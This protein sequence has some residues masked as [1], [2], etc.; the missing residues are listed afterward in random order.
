MSNMS[1]MSKQELRAH[2]PRPY[3]PLPSTDFDALKA[4]Y[5]ASPLASEEDTFALIRIIGND[6][7]PRHQ[8]GQSRMNLE[9][10]LEHEPKFDACTKVWVLN[11]IV[12]PD[13]LS[14]LKALLEKYGGEYYEI[15]FDENEYARI[16]WDL[17]SFEV[18]NFL[19][20]KELDKLEDGV[21]STAWDQVYRYKNCYAMNNNGAR[22][23]ALNL[24][25]Q[26]AKWILPWDG[27]CFLTT[28]AW[29]DIRDAVT[30]APYLK[31]FTVPM[32]RVA[33]NADLLDAAFEPHAVEEPQMLF[34]RD[35]QEEF[36]ENYRYGRRPKVELFWRLGIPGPW[37]RW[38][39]QQ[40][41]APFPRLS[42]EAGCVG[43]A[44]W[45]ARLF[46]GMGALEQNDQASF[47]NRGVARQSAVRGFLDSLDAKSMAART[48]T[49]KLLCMRQER[50]AQQREAW[51][52][53]DASIRPVVEKLLEDAD[54]AVKRGRLSVV[55]KTTLPPSADPHDYWH[56][57][58][59]WWPNPATADGTPYIRRDGE[60]VAG[61]RMYE[62]DSESYD[63]T[64]A[65]HL[66]DDVCILA[67]A[68]YFSGKREY[69][70]RAAEN[71]RVWFLNG[72][73]RMAPHLQYSQVRLGHNGNQGA[74]TGV[75]EFKDLYYM[76]DGVKLLR[77]EGYLDESLIRG[78]NEWFHAYLHWLQTSPQGR[79]ERAARNNHGVLYDLQVLAVAHFVGEWSEV[80]QVVRRARDRLG[81]HFDLE[82]RQPHELVRTLTKH[83]CAFNLQSWANL[84]ASLDA[85]GFDL[86]N[87]RHINGGSLEQAFKWFLSYAGVEWPFPQI[88]PF[89]ER[90]FEPLRRH[91]S[92]VYFD[93]SDKADCGDPYGAEELRAKFWPHDGIRPYWQLG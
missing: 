50:L 14:K 15:P 61:T 26:R 23:V 44:G 4:G 58:P 68:A 57:A 46:S 52:D 45:V 32:A 77:G 20:S 6:L 84:G 88:E 93:W 55:D 43:Q 7:P 8:L 16:D 65:Q 78:L 35:S 31:Y 11:R 73:T 39:N 70:Q 75:I 37:D 27:N 17:D 29:D 71:L 28:A 92:S 86:W 66:F 83:Y 25:R 1:N 80:M 64:R 47:K 38:R 72:A 85:L 91:A 9:F 60:R 34:R 56:P 21:K 82:G 40:W 49:E 12:E 13:E 89:D 87:Y 42:P 30:S 69:G 63:R 62:P 48:S 22:N 36:A 19:D 81:D 10:M 24:G 76:L 90:R 74:S 59:Y 2:Y 41:D 18:P 3:Q 79:R 5:S 67:L 33:N 51:R 53:N 54:D